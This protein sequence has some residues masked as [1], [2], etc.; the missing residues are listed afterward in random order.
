MTGSL[1]YLTVSRPDIMFSVCLCARFQSNREE[2][3]AI[4]IKRVF[5]YFKHTPNLGI[6]YPK[7]I[8]YDLVACTYA[9]YAGSRVN[10]K[11]TSGSYQL[12]GNMIVSW[13][14]KK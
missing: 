7:D 10:K 3:H 14:C 11:N 8:S 2:S 9:D 1:L 6:W 12:L 13:C 4:I 5:C